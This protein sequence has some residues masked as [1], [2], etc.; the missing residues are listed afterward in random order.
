MTIWLIGGTQESAE[1]AE[2]MMAL[3]LPCVVTVVS[4]SARSLYPASL[5]IWVGQLSIEQIPDFL[6]QYQIDRILDA[7]HPFAVAISQL[8]I[9]VSE[10]YRIPYLRYE[11][12]PVNAATDSAIKPSIEYFDSVAALLSTDRL[13]NQRVLLTVGYRSLPLFASWQQQ[14]YLFA[15]ILP[16]SVALE[17]ALAAG[18]TPDRIIALRPPIS[19]A[20]E[21]ALWQQWQISTV[22]TKA[23][24]TAGGEAVKQ[25]VAAAL[26]VKLIV[27][28]RPAIAYPQQ[29]SD[30]DM[31]LSFCK[32]PLSRQETG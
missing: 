14:A 12:P 4:E 8:A 21:T 22:V 23:S 13:V 26:G 3:H 25:Q 7:S 5:P 10:R 30:P 29:T 28:E 24:G 1:L 9:T 27:I 16:S 15:R 31:A 6:Q 19:V 20:L 2:A 17:T 18:F 11:R 32:R